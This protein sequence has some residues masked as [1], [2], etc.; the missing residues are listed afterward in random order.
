MCAVW[1][2]GC[3]AGVSRGRVRVRPRFGWMDGEKVAL[4][5]RELTVEASWQF[6]NDSKEWRA[7]VHM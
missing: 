1:P 4:G 6:E 7:L 5:N 3:M 2:E